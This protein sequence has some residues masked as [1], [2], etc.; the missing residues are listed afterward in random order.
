[1]NAVYL[2]NVKTD[3]EYWLAGCKERCGLFDD[4]SDDDIFSIK[5][6]VI[7]EWWWAV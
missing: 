7:S 6:R 4:D 1:M 3:K 2:C 5:T